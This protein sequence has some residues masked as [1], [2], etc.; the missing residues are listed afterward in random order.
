MSLQE[1]FHLW[2]QIFSPYGRVDDVYIMRDEQKQS[3]G[4]N[5]FPYFAFRTLLQI[6]NEPQNIRF[7][8]E[9]LTDIKVDSGSLS[10][11]I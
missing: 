8:M 11:Q 6:S 5:G 3:R 9:P 2:L 1:S 7:K 10:S 4:L